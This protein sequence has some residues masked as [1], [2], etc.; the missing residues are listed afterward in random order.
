LP[1]QRGNVLDASSLRQSNCVLAA[2]VRAFFGNES[3][4]GLAAQSP[5]TVGCR[6]LAAAGDALDIGLPIPVPARPRN[7]LGTDLLPADVGVQRREVDAK[8]LRGS[9]GRNI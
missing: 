9:F 7:R 8:H 4:V 2:I 5:G 3:D 1:K 6:L